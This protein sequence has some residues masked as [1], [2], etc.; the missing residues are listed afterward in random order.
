MDN[1]RLAHI[2]ADLVLI[3]GTVFYFHRK[4]SLLQEHI[5]QLKREQ[6]ELLD[7]IDQLKA[8]MQQL[9]NIVLKNRPVKQHKHKRT[10]VSQAPMQQ[11]PIRQEPEL[12]NSSDS[13][14][15]NEDE[16]DKELA[17]E[18]KELKCDGDTCVLE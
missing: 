16:L 13:E 8:G 10:V 9:A 11:A 1:V 7:E 15:L 5:L 18:Y 17:Q 12:S 14:S 2:G 4:T 3:G 6:H